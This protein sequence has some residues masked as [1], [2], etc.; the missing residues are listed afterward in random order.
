MNKVT[1]AA[2]NVKITHNKQQ[3]LQHFEEIIAHCAGRGVDLLVFPEVA[4]QGYADFGYRFFDPEFAEQRREMM[5][6][7]ETI[8]GPSTEVI[9]RAVERHGM[10][11]QV[12]MAEAVLDGNI[13]YNSTALIGPEGVV[14]VFRKIHAYPD[15]QIGRA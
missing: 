3:N 9:R 12:G 5:R 13:L 7:A 8:P 6:E 10:Y 11:V 4:L 2:A 14:G 15:Y 1:L